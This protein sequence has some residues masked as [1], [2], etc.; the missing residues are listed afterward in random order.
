[1]RSA[2]RGRYTQEFKVEAVRLV[3][4]R[5]SMADA[6]TQPRGWAA[7]VVELGQG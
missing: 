6:S 4:S 5:Q 2:T 3:E 1:M 7:D